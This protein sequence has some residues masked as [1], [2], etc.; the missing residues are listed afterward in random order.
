MTDFLVAIGLVLCIEGMLY[1][2]APGLVR[3]LAAELPRMSDAA[4]RAGGLAAAII[5]VI[6]VWIVRGT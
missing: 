2:L 6:I 3:R 4:L 5:G 1:A